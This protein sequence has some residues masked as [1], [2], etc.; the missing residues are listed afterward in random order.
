MTTLPDWAVWLFTIFGSIG[1]VSVLY[2]GLHAAYW[3][4][5]RDRRPLEL[6]EL[7][8]AEYETLKAEW[9]EKFGRRG[10]R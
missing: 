9:A 3:L 6:R 8:D 7:T 10:T 2:W 5:N 4:A 1:V